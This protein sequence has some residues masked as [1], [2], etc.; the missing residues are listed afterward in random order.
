MHCMIAGW[1]M[2]VEEDPANS[3]EHDADADLHSESFLHPSSSFKDVMK[4]LLF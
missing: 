1:V 2:R 3:I 4:S